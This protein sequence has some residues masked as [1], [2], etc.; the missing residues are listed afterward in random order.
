MNT[1][2]KH[3][4]TSTFG[5]LIAMALLVPQP[6]AAEDA[7]TYPGLMCRSVSGDAAK[8]FVGSSNIDLNSGH[9]VTC[10]IVRDTANSDFFKGYV[11]SA[12]ITVIDNSPVEDVECSLI[13][14]YGS[15]KGIH[16]TSGMSSAPKTLQLGTFRADGAAYQIDCRIPKASPIGSGD[17]NYSRI[18]SYR[19]NE[20]D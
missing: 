11:R 13:S 4:V 9:T 17:F 19:V 14:S 20:D 18:I 2:V 8:F 1:N 15:S 12:S 6:A 10:A 16:R 3:I 7:K 5:S